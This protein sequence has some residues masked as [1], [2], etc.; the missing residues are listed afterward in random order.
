MAKEKKNITKK[1]LMSKLKILDLEDKDTRDNIVCSLIGHS[2]IVTTC[3]GYLHC[4]R[5]EA[6][7]G[8]SL[9]GASSTETNVIIGHKC[10]ICEKNY[11]LCTW[12][13][14]LYVKNPF[15]VKEKK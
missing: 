8:D 2:K 13:D 1:E 11:K 6:Q 14:K 4:G 10:K 5:C 12:K 7:I 9:G 3:F 15:G